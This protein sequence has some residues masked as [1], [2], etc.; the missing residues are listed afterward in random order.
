[1]TPLSVQKAKKEILP[2]LDLRKRNLKAEIFFQSMCNSINGAMGGSE[3]DSP[4]N[5]IF[6]FVNKEEEKE[7]S[8][9][10]VNNRALNAPSF[11]EQPQN[12]QRQNSQN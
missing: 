4:R 1:M 7:L 5:K 10:S 8:F 3:M 9:H 6:G 11:V 2:L 12:V